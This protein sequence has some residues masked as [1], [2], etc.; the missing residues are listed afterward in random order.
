MGLHWAGRRPTVCAYYK[1]Y[2]LGVLFKGADVRREDALL[3]GDFSKAKVLAPGRVEQVRQ[4]CVV[5]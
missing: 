5:S 1:S 4:H 3:G 2:S